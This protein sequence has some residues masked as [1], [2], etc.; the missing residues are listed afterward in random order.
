M[1]TFA[2]A[3]HNGNEMVVWPRD[4][5][6]TRP[7]LA[8]ARIMTYDYNSRVFDNVDVNDDPREWANDLLLQIEH[9]REVGMVSRGMFS[10]ASDPEL[11]ST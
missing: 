7:E 4:I 9:V 6:P 2:K 8:Q 3:N 1:D 10:V 11:T 5:L